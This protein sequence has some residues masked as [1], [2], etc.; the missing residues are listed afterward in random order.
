[1][2]ASRRFG[3]YK[4]EP[5]KATRDLDVR[6]DKLMEELTD[7]LTSLD[8]PAVD[9]KW[10]YGMGADP[11]PDITGYY[12]KISRFDI[13]KGLSSEEVERFSCLLVEFEG[14]PD[15]GIKVGIF[16]SAM[17]NLGKEEHY[18]VNTT[19]IADSPYTLRFLGYLNNKDMMV[20]GNGGN[21]LGCRM[22][23]GSIIVKGGAGNNA[24]SRMSEGRILIEGDCGSD[25]G[26]GMRGGIIRIKGNAGKIVGYRMKGGEIHIEGECGDIVNKSITGG[27]IYHKGN[28]IVER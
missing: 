9:E 26:D 10:G 14:I 20:I 3:K 24:G 8:I 2:A 16:L 23:E 18:T 19:G 6:G 15:I 1:M 28:L 25:A 22:E 13:L 27:K 21:S 5:G 17:I 11:R 12:E 4:K 7:I